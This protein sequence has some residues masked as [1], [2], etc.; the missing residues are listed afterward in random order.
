MTELITWD[1]DEATCHMMA[2]RRFTTAV[3]RGR[4]NKLGNVTGQEAAGGRAGTITQE[5]HH[6]DGKR[7]A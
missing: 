4:I 5:T 6:T 3:F 2:G 7:S 1:D